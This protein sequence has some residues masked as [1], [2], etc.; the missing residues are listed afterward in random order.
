ML[1]MKLTDPHKIVTDILTNYA[2]AELSSPR[3]NKTAEALAH[4]LSGMRIS[5][6]YRVDI[7]EGSRNLMAREF[8]R[9]ILTDHAV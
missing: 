5:R 1:G 6:Y 3:G 7:P 4:L 8:L 2:S 9:G